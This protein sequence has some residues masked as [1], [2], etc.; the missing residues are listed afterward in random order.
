MALPNLMLVPFFLCLNF[1]MKM[2]ISFAELILFLFQELDL[3]DQILLIEVGVFDIP[4][5]LIV[6]AF[7]LLLLRRTSDEPEYLRRKSDKRKTSQTIQ[8]VQYLQ[9]EIVIQMLLNS[10]EAV[11][12][13]SVVYQADSVL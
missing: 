8:R 2:L 10:A 4:N 12:L 11:R 1:R 9:P 6:V 3:K 5:S 13:A 7:V